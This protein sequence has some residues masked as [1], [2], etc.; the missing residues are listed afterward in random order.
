MS[1]VHGGLR[2]AMRDFTE[3]GEKLA[4]LVIDEQSGVHQEFVEAQ[5]AT[6]IQA[7]ALKLPVWLIELNPGLGKGQPSTPTV[8]HLKVAGARVCQKPHLNAFVKE[9]HPNLHEE[10]KKVGVTMLVMM[11]YHVNC[12]V[13]ATCVGGPD[14]PGG[15]VWRPGATQLG[16]T[17]LTSGWILRGGEAT[18]WM[19]KGVRFYGQI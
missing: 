5:D 10:L 17:V 18:W 15:K 12:C 13:K 7:V 11:G 14:R 2:Q 3:R 4:V 8:G 6:L 16:Y 19:E 9:A 1:I